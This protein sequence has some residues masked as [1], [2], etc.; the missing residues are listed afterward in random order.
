MKK[1]V[2]LSFLF[3]SFI[4]F[5]QDVVKTKEEIREEIR[6]EIREEIRKEIEEEAKEV[7]EGWTKFGKITFLVNQS[8]FSNWLAGGDNNFS[9]NLNLNYDINYKKGNWSV[10]N[11]ILIG[12]GISN[13]KD[14]G[15]RK[16][17]DRI[18]L[19]SILSK[20][21]KG[22]WRFS[23]FMNFK[24]Q[25]TNGYIYDGVFV[26]QNP[27]E[28]NENYR[29]SG[30]FKPAYWGFGPGIFWEKHEKFYINISPLTSKFTLISGEIFTYNDDD[31]DN[32]FYESS[33]DVETFGVA[34]G[35]IS[36]YQF[37]INIRAYYMVDIMENITAENILNIYSNYLDKPGNIDI[38][39]TVKFVMRINDV[40]SANF[41][42][43]T[44]YDDNAFKGFQIREIFGLGVYVKL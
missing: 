32:V 18:E 38:D 27:G 33:N 8:A 31:P 42:F 41:I 11:K 37:G 15:A 34:P 19:N 17:D 36:L 2:L 24:T 29:T 14:E 1:L 21:L 5:A 10:D 26:S 4:G 28:D 12:Y 25:F 9:G 22:Y 44:I 43:Q 7:K 35:K 39:Y 16:S 13:F 30:F 40:F 23:F 20:K 3:I 6:K